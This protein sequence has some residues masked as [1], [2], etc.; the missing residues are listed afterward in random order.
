MAT[1]SSSSK[2]LKPSA[3]DRATAS[4]SLSC[5]PPPSPWFTWIARPIGPEGGRLGRGGGGRGAPARLGARWRGDSLHTVG[6]IGVQLHRG[7]E[8][9][10]PLPLLVR[11]D[12]CEP[13][14]QVRARIVGLEL[15]DLPVEVDR[16]LQIP[17]VVADDRK[18][19]KSVRERRIDAEREPVVGLR[20]SQRSIRLVD[21]SEVEVGEF[22]VRVVDEN[23]TVV[24]RGLGEATGVLGGD[25][26][27][28]SL[29]RE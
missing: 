22:V 15:D 14:V 18:V 13:E 23:L 7:L 6:E 9:G 28:H 11:L 29:A 1:V 5:A 17:Q 27:G 2:A 20:R 26:L 25:A 8:L 10:L 4:M 24:G 16:F 19:E 12:E 3:A 21:R